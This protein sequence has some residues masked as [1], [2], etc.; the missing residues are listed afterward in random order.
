MKRYLHPLRGDRVKFV[1]R[2][3][4][5]QE[6]SVVEYLSDSLNGEARY[7]IRPDVDPSVT[8]DVRAREIEVIDRSDYR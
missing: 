1:S 7:G 2:Y 4:N 5:G 3:R 8:A 6:G